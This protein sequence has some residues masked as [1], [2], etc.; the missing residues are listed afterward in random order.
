MGGGNRAALFVWPK[1]SARPTRLCWPSCLLARLRQI[2]GRSQCEKGAASLPNDRFVAGRA[3]ASSM[4]FG[5]SWGRWPAG[6]PLTG[7]RESHCL[8]CA[9]VGRPNL[10]AKI[11]RPTLHVMGSRIAPGPARCASGQLGLIC[12]LAQPPRA[13]ASTNPTKLGHPKANQPELEDSKQV[14]PASGQPR[15]PTVM[16]ARGSMLTQITASAADIREAGGVARAMRNHHAPT[17]RPA[18]LA[19]IWLPRPH[20]V[21][22]ELAREPPRLEAGLPS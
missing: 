5:S 4:D 9:R 3:L 8:L 17:D 10:N 15:A 14:S 11:T 7:P 6:S 22:F 2:L 13:A 19:P 18:G 12:L 1:F 21:P 20:V 16:G